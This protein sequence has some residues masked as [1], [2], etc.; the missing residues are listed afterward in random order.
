MN[1]LWLVFEGVVMR[2]SGFVAIGAAVALAGCHSDKLMTE[3]A[4]TRGD[5]LGGSHAYL[6]PDKFLTA[7]DADGKAKQSQYLIRT[8]TPK[9]FDI[10][11]VASTNKKI[12]TIEERDQFSLRCAPKGS[13]GD[14]PVF[15]NPIFNRSLPVH[16]IVYAYNHTHA[17][18]KPGEIS[19]PHS[20]VPGLQIKFDPEYYGTASIKQ[21]DTYAVC[22]ELKSRNNGPAKPFV[23]DAN[24]TL[25]LLPAPS[26]NHGSNGGTH[27]AVVLDVHSIKSE[28]GNK[29]YFTAVG[30]YRGN[31]NKPAA[32]LIWNQ[33]GSMA[34]LS[35]V[36][37]SAELK[38]GW[39]ITRALTISSDDEIGFE[40]VSPT[41]DIHFGQMVE[42]S[43]DKN[44]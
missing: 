11:V 44:K 12:G 14:I 23:L 15:G 7:H 13:L 10:A 25:Y 8:Q 26:T 27:S 20:S 42:K 43:L 4:I 2:V 18:I 35:K 19:Y 1:Q 32:G 5:V 24:G 21:G 16:S 9:T 30:T 17:L 34:D 31:D 36:I 6:S 29:I 3:N 28:T 41:G 22:G 39:K 37:D 38:P 40:V 33:D